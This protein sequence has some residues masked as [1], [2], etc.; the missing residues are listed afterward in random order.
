MVTHDYR[1][2]APE[3]YSLKLKKYKYVYYTATTPPSYIIDVKYIMYCARRY[4][5]FQY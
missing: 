5:T 2:T 3:T 1:V 4:S